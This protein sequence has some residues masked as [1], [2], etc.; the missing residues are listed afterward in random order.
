M[1]SVAHPKHFLARSAIAT[2]VVAYAKGAS[3][4]LVLSYILTLGDGRL[5]GDIRP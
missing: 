4:C 5:F 1:Y 2:L 3:S